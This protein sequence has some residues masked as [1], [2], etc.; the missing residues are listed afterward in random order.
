[1][2]KGM[3]FNREMLERALAKKIFKWVDGVM[4]EIVPP[5]IYA[6]AH[7]GNPD[8]RNRAHNWLKENGYRIITPGEGYVQVFKGTRLVR[9]TRLVLELTDPDELL[10]IAEAVKSHTNLPAPP[11]WAGPMTNRS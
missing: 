11:P 8:D 3:K 7:C 1:M 9:Q 10:S 5:D 6:S 2:A 4:K